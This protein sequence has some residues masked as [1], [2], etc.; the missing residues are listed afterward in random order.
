MPVKVA[1]VSKKSIKEDLKQKKL[2]EKQR[3]QKIIEEKQKNIDNFKYIISKYDIFNNLINDDCIDKNIAD[4]LTD[5][6]NVLKIYDSKEYVDIEDF[7]KSFGGKKRRN[8][9]GATR[10]DNMFNV[11]NS[12]YRYKFFDYLLFDKY[13]RWDPINDKTF[14]FHD[15]EMDYVK[16]MLNW[17][18]KKKKY[19]IINNLL[20]DDVMNIIYQYLGKPTLSL[21]LRQAVY[22]DMTKV[23][24][25]EYNREI[26]WHNYYINTGYPRNIPPVCKKFSVSKKSLYL[27]GVIMKE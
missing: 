13:S 12:V 5:L 24:K 27:E 11:H 6:S 3:K 25:I 15:F 16:D 2:L 1:K 18:I 21:K 14:N 20:P 17:A 23:Y 7:I 4:S 19:D 26:Y 8:Y 22:D 9:M 10:R